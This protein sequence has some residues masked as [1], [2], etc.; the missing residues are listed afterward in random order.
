MLNLAAL[1]AGVDR[2]PGPPRRS[3]DSTD[4]TMTFV[5][6]ATL[7][8]LDD[9]QHERAGGIHDGLVQ[10]NEEFL[11]PSV[12]RRREGRLARVAAGEISESEVPS[13]VVHDP[14]AAPSASL[15]LPHEVI[16]R[17]VAFLLLAGAHTS[18][19]AFVRAIDHILS[20][21]EAH[22]DDAP[23][24]PPDRCSCSGAST[25]RCA[26]TRPARSGNAGR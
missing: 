13:D 3:R 10:W 15:E 5:E 26:S 21:V 20:W 16:R 22:P 12:A 24:G 25:R 9:G 1:T 4:Y 17:E 14:A 18:A 8:A 7:G 19:T 11:R 2:P 23:E 6:G